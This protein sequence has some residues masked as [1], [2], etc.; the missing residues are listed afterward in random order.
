MTLNEDVPPIVYRCLTNADISKIDDYIADKMTAAVFADDKKGSDSGEFTTSETIYYWM[1]C[2]GIPFE[3]ESWNFNKLFAL[4]Q[5]CSAKNQPTKK[6]SM[7]EIYS[8]NNALN[9]KRKAGMM[10]R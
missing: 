4:I 7:R 10:K 8:R 9:A 2:L 3:C 6:L 1:I 5:F